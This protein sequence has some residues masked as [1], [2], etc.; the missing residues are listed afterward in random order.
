MP[1]YI[2]LHRETLERRHYVIDATLDT[3]FFNFWEGR[4]TH[5]IGLYHYDFCLVINGS[6][7][8]DHAFILPFKD[9]RDFF[10]H[11]YLDARHRWVG[12]IRL[13]DEVIVISAN[14]VSKEKP[15][16]EFHNA[17]HLLQDAP[18]PLPK[19]PDISELI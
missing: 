2:T 6:V 5:Y 13:H 18:L 7:T 11:D 12:N 16:F 15:A 4:F 1:S 17:F 8:T 19:G 3:M 14:A 9:F 10:T